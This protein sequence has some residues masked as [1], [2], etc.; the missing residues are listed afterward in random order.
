MQP[1]KGSGRKTVVYRFGNLDFPSENAALPTV[2]RYRNVLIRRSLQLKTRMSAIAGPLGLEPRMPDPESGVL[3]ITPRAKRG[4]SGDRHCECV[5]IPTA[6]GAVK[7]S[8]FCIGPAECN[9]H[10]RALR[11]DS[12]HLQPL[13]DV[14]DGHLA[15]RVR[16]FGCAQDPGH[17][18]LI[19]GVESARCAAP[20]SPFASIPR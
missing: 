8:T 14:G 7:S 4:G 11:F 13:P 6:D 18:L 9:H 15:E 1:S 20:G 16:L 2:G 19:A 12:N 17:K 3:P 5:T 10:T